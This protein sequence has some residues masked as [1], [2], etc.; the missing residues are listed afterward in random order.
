MS[1]KDK[2]DE[3]IKLLEAEIDEYAK[4]VCDA[5]AAKGIDC[6]HYE[7]DYAGIMV[8]F[9]FSPRAGRARG[10]STTL[11][12]SIEEWKGQ[13]DVQFMAHS[14]DLYQYEIAQDYGPTLT[15]PAAGKLT[16]S[17]RAKVLEHWKRYRERVEPE[18]ISDTVIGYMRGIAPSG[19]AQRRL[20]RR[21]LR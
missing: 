11:S 4:E 2:E 17:E 21:L 20:K 16:A 7:D 1:K 5:A 14:D 6:E 3:V 13:L 12:A 10:M 18:A 15:L 9:M 8:S 19:L